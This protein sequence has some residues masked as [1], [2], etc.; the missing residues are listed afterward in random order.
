[1]VAFA[2]G[3]QA[4]DERYIATAEEKKDA[5]L[6]CCGTCAVAAYGAHRPRNSPQP[7][8]LLTPAACPAVEY[9]EKKSAVTVGNLGDSRA[10]AGKFRGGKMMVEGLSEDHSV[11][12][13]PSERDRLRKEF[14]DLPAIIT[15]SGGTDDRPTLKATSTGVGVISVSQEGMRGS[16]RVRVVEALPIDEDFEGYPLEKAPGHWLGGV[17][18]WEVLERDGSK[19]LARKMDNPLFQRTISFIGHPNTSNYTMKVDV[20]TDGNRR[21]MSSAGVIH[22]RYQISLKGNYREIE[23]S[24]N[25]ERLKVSKPYRVKAGTWY[26]L[27]TRVDVNDDGSGTVRA[28]VWVRGEEEPAEWTIEVPHND[29]HVEGSPGIYGFTPQSQFRVYLDNLVVTPNE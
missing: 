6:M 8:Q 17:A 11:A 13:S 4:A 27:L 3:L 7:A 24:S 2:E 28:K 15:A 1:M 16:S 20:M 9:G 21:S 23:V 29:A 14:P 5:V 22:Q 19:V 18:K 26:T 12:T 10:V 25:M